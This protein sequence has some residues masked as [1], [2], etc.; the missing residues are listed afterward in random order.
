MA[1]L[2]ARA[3]K[4]PKA[5]ND[6]AHKIKKVILLNIIIT[7]CA[8]N[9][10]LAAEMPGGISFYASNAADKYYTILY[11][12]RVIIIIIYFMSNYTR[13]RLWK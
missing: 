6:V 8:G 5:P 2:C 7:I 10:T 1:L 13:S 4:K 11:I 9:N 3:R 12:S